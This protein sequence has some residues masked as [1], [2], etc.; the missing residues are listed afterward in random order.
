MLKD[1]VVTKSNDLN[2]RAYRLS[3]VEQLLV[4]S[5][6]S[7]VEPEDEDFKTYRLVIKDFLD[8]LN[9]QDQSKYTELP[10]ITRGLMTKVIEIKKPHSLLQVAWFCSVEH[11]PS[12][13]FIEIQFSSKLKPY[14]LNLKENFV[15][16]ALNEVSKF[17]SRYSIRIYELLKQNQFKKTV[18]FEINNFRDLI[19]LE[20]TIYP[21]Y[22]NLKQKVIIVAQNELNIKSDITFDFEEI[23]TGRSVTS[24]KFYIHSNKTNKTNKPNVEIAASSISDIEIA[25][26]I[27]KIMNLMDKHNINPKEALKIYKSSKGDIDLI[28]KIYKYAVT[29][30]VNNI[31]GYMINLLNEGFNEPKQNLKK[32]N[33]TNYEGQRKYNYQEL[34]EKLLEIDNN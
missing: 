23:K 3:R 1:N 2:L 20:D 19:G 29:K 6:A 25:E 17:S 28:S 13:G 16:Y 15:S 4:L 30:N 32:D 33:F 10:K 18:T 9:I 5:V 26:E 11:M 14:L 8:L 22:S 12:Q 31:V 24:L 34:E 21:K 27:D 7:M